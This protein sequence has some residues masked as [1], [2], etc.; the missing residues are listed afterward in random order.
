[1]NIKKHILSLIALTFFIFIAV[2]SVD[3]DDTSGSSSSEKS[4]K[5]EKSKK[6]KKSS[7]KYRCAECGDSFS[8]APYQCIMYMCNKATKSVSHALDKY[9]SCSCGV[10]SKARDGFNY[11]CP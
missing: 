11:S 1:M 4:E 7:S 5:S 9:C 2:G 10:R 6:S 8:G 3:G